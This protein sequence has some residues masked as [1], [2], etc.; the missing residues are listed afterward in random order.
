MTALDHSRDLREKFRD[1]M[2]LGYCAFAKLTAPTPERADELEAQYMRVVGRYEDKDVIRAYK[3][4]LHMAWEVVEQGGSDF[5]GEAAGLMNILDKGN[6]QFFT[7]YEVAMLNAKMTLTGIE[8]LI[9]RNGY[10]T[11]AEPAAGSG[12]MVLAAMDVLQQE[13]IH[14]HDMLV[15]AVDVSQMCYYMLYLQLTWRGVAAWVERA[16]SL[17]LESFDGAWTV[18]AIAFKMRH[19]H[20]SFNGERRSRDK[21]TEDMVN[22][23]REL[24]SMVNDMASAIDAVQDEPQE[25]AEPVSPLDENAEQDYPEPPLPERLIQMEM[26]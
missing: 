12:V 23:M 24:L 14:P 25:P 9:E 26:F 7:P 16:N 1:M 22:K 18:N 19:G 6:E 5:L 8:A 20:L 11:M 2:E 13:G 21:E 10:F 17:S 15:H 3:P 4:L